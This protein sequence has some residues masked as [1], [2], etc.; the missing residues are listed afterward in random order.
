M[1]NYFVFYSMINLSGELEDPCHIIM[2]FVALS[3]LGL[4]SVYNKRIRN[5]HHADNYRSILLNRCSLIPKWTEQK[6]FKNCIKNVQ[7]Q[8]WRKKKETFPDNVRNIREQIQQASKEV[9]TTPDNKR[10]KNGWT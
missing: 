2:I 1:R 3:V 9:T 5:D 6:L 8:P 10:R 7:E 4:K